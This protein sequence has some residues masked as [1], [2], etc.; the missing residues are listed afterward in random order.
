LICCGA[1]ERL[2]RSGASQIPY[3]S[4][5]PKRRE[6]VS[7]HRC[8]NAAAPGTDLEMQARLSSLLAA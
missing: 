1:P 7:E 6:K 2:L 4:P 5:E 3:G 8:Y